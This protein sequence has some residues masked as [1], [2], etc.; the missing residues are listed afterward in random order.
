MHKT[1]RFQLASDQVAAVG[2]SLTASANLLAL[3]NMITPAQ[4]GLTVARAACAVSRCHGHLAHADELL[5][6]VLRELDAYQA[7]SAIAQRED[8]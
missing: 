8:R 7:E 6:A 3:A 1:T 5:R 2:A 4:E